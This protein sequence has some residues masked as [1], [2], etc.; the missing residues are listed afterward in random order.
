MGRVDREKGL[1]DLVQAVYQGE[2]SDYQVAI[3]GKGMYRDMLIEKVTDLRISDQVV[4]PGFV[5]SSDLPALLNSIDA[6]MM[7]S[8]AE[9]QSIATLEAMSC[10]LPILAA[11]ARALPELVQHEVNGLLFN[12]HNP[13]NLAATIDRF[14][15]MHPRWHWMGE[16]SLE[17]VQPHQIQNT[18]QRYVEWYESVCG[19]TLI[20]QNSQPLRYS[21][22][23]AD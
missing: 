22:Q 11:N 9:L 2:R 15:A 23:I 10:G 14:L 16:A 20:M 1:D 6:F 8:A 18:I 4:F 5:P 13:A 3:A 7:P 19:R 21:A 12:A 17:R